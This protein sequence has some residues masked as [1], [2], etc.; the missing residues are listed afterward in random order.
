MTP[1]QF[2]EANVIFAKDQQEYLPLP[3]HRVGNDVGLVNTCWEL[4]D[5]EIET[6]IMTK[7]VWVSIY[8]FNKPLVPIMLTVNRSELYETPERPV[9]DETPLQDKA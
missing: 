3:A 1:I 2:P 5:E 8:T 7:K 4:S 9:M 6:L